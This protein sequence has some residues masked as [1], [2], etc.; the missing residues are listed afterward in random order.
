MSGVERPD[1]TMLSW[2]HTSL[3]IKSC[4]VIGWV[5]ILGD[6]ASKLEVAGVVELASCTVRSCTFSS[7]QL[8]I[9]GCR[10]RQHWLLDHWRQGSKAALTQ[11]HVKLQ[12]VACPAPV[13][14]SSSPRTT[15]HG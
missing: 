15:A 8:D 10:G 7:G 13:E 12:L 9:V 3:S 1:D 2:E 4:R 6:N 11:V 5:G 14:L